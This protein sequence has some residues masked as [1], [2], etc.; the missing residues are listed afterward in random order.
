MLRT[1]ASR[2]PSCSSHL[3]TGSAR[4]SRASWTFSSHIIPSQRQRSLHS[5]TVESNK[6]PSFDG[7]RPAPP[8]LPP[9]LQKEFEELQRKAATPLASSSSAE[10]SSK[11]L[12]EEHPDMRKKPK[13]EFE[14]DINPK[15]GEVGGPKNNPLSYEKEWTYGGRAT[16]F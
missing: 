9:H 12:E 13:P 3:I 2:C 4:V 11:P 6:V 8:R 5:S 7:D 1:I 16:D 14:G 10:V 15:T